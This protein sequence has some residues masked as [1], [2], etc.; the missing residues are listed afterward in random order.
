[1]NRP[2]DFLVVGTQKGGTTALD[3]FLRQHPE[4]CLPE[5]KE[6]H[7]FDDDTRFGI[8]K[9]DF[10]W[11]ESQ[12]RPL[13][14][15]KL[16]GE[17]TPAYMYWE[18]APRRIWQYNRGMKLI[19]L[20]R[21][22]IERA[23]SHWNMQRLRGLE[24]REF[25]V[26]LKEEHETCRKKLPFQCRRFS[27]IAR[28][29]YTEQ[30]LRLKRYFPSRQLLILRSDEFRE[31]PASI[32]EEV[33]RFLGVS[34]CGVE[35]PVELAAHALPYEAPMEPEAWHY[36][37]HLFEYEIRQLERMLEWD[38]EEWMVSPAL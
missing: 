19:A 21:N 23:F 5:A 16:L 27:Y 22:P 9:P 28:G 15:H 35:A 18:E 14:R 3:F 10:S 31:N 6:L 38:C 20:L 34:D 25:L 13:F 17:C 24:K 8:G 26:A 2:L 37:F 12:F 29:Y 32:M 4:I 33:W 30:I 7:F 11:Y 36:L 1:M